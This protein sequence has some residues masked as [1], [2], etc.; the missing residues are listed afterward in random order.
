MI[1]LPIWLF[2][3]VCVFATPVALVLLFALLGLIVWGISE[4]VYLIKGEP[5]YDKEC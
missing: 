4:L 3:I 1:T 2:V 5:D